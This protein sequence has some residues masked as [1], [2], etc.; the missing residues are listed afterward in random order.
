MRRSLLVV[1]A[2]ALVGT[3]AWWFWPGTAEP[4]PA[5]RPDTVHASEDE[6]DPASTPSSAPPSAAGPVVQSAPLPPDDAPLAGILDTLAARADAG[7]RK[8]ACRLGLEL[9]R[10][11]QLGDEEARNASAERARSAA[12]ADSGKGPSEAEAEDERWKRH[13][14]DQCQAVPPTLRGQG[15]HYLRQA[16]R[17]GEPEAMV[18]YADGQHWPSSGQGILA[19]PAFDQWRREAPGMMLRALES[20]YPAAAFPLTIAYSDDTSLHAALVPDDPEQALTMNLLQARL[21]GSQASSFM[22]GRLDAATQ[23]RARQRAEALHQAHFQGRL[24][25]GHYYPPH[26]GFPPP[27]NEPT[28][29]FCRDP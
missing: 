16:A 9:L 12:V 21:F 26:V 25:K 2:T 18:R 7:D 24:F 14:L 8:A 19:G 4:R 17:A 1:V 28:H 22:R 3:A 29:R 11:S 13:W 15:G 20:G 23:L 5:S 6:V 10:C 27:R